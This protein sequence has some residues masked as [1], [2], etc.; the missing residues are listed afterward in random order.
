MPYL[1]AAGIGDQGKDPLFR[2]A[3]NTVQLSQAKDKL[4]V[5]SL[6]ASGVHELKGFSLI[7]ANINLG[8]VLTALAADTYVDRLSKRLSKRGAKKIPLAL[9]PLHQVCVQHL[10]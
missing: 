2:T 10:P 1:E 7:F 6:V 5:V 9:F 8:E 3:P 4:A